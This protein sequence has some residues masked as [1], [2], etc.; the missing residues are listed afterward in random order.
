MLLDRH[1]CPRHA[2]CGDSRTLSAASPS[3]HRQS[4]LGTLR[5]RATRQGFTPDA[6]H[7]D[8]G[9]GATRRGAG[10]CAAA[11]ASFC[12]GN[13]CGSAGRMARPE[14]LELPTPRFVVWCSIQLSYGRNRRR[15]LPPRT[16]EASG[17]AG[18][19]QDGADRPPH[20][21]TCLWLELGL[22]SICRGFQDDK[23]MIS[24]SRRNRRACFEWWG[25]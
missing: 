10:I 23:A 6:R 13:R 14:R 4:K 12:G 5:G 24:L 3:R 1:R 25:R 17:I 2:I 8:R 16:P 20:D 15:S 19:R 9:F 22:R 7:G 11:R 18:R 21:E